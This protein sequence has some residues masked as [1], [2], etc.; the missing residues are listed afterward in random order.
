M[1][2]VSRLYNGHDSAINEYGAVGGMRIGKG[3]WNTWRKHA[4][5]ST[6]RVS[7]DKHEHRCELRP[8]SSKWAISAGWT[9]EVHIKPKLF[10]LICDCS[11]MILTQNSSVIKYH[12]MD[13]IWPESH[14]YLYVNYINWRAFLNLFVTQP[15]SSQAGWMSSTQGTFIILK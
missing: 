5:L 11:F 2:L 3:N 9:K 12:L 8:F 7:A 14:S 10:C 6:V 1:L 4:T 13:Q 15:F